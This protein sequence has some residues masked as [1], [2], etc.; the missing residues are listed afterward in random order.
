VAELELE[1]RDVLNGG[2]DISQERILKVNM[3]TT[4]NPKSVSPATLAA[5]GTTFAF[6]LYVGRQRMKHPHIP[7]PFLASIT[8]IPRMLWGYSGRAHEI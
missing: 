2:T 3:T 5:V 4:L 1:K 8:N 7:G 6:V